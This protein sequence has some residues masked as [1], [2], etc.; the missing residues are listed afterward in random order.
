MRKI[1][2]PVLIVFALLLSAC[3]TAKTATTAAAATSA[4][5]AAAAATKIDLTWNF[6]CSSDLDFYAHP[7]RA[8]PSP[9]ASSRNCSEFQQILGLQCTTGQ[10]RLIS[11]ANRPLWDTQLLWANWWSHQW[12]RRSAR[13]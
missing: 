4:P 12:V 7:S 11:Y 6:M 13:P 2:F 5:T 8:K 1:F 3:G 9:I 10:L